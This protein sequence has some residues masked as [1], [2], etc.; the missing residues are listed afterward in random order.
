MNDP[1]RKTIISSVERAAKNH[2]IQSSDADTI[3][4]AMVFCVE[5][6]EQLN[7]GAKLLLS[8]H[9][10]IVVESPVEHVEEVA[11]VVVSSVDDAFNY[12][13]PVMPMYTAP[14]IGPCW[15]KGE[16]E[17]KDNTG[18]K[19]EHN[20]MQFAYDEHYGS[21]LVCAKCGGKQD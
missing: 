19:C 10:E 8:V 17:I 20:V 18:K 11:K 3:K 2:R 7:V 13:F 16:C 1:A 15:I 14:V 12:Y 4:L 21:K 5:R 9:D 6:L